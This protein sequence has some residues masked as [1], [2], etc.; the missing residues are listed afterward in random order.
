MRLRNKM[1]L[2]DRLNHGNYDRIAIWTNG[3]WALVDN[4]YS[5]E[6]S[7]DNPVFIIRRTYFGE[8]THRAIKE[9]FDLLETT[10]L[11]E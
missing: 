1:K 8:M 6:K 3:T 11:E 10:V 5:G 7:G 9:L 4:N 2:R